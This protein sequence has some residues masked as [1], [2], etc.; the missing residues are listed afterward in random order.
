MSKTREIFPYLESEENN[1]D[2]HALKAGR[3]VFILF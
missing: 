1:V 2:F 3:I